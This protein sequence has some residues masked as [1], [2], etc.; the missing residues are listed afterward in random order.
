MPL[1]ISIDEPMKTEKTL[2]YQKMD[3]DA[4]YCYSSHLDKR[5]VSTRQSEHNPMLFL[6]LNRNII[7][8]HELC[9][10]FAGKHMIQDKPKGTSPKTFGTIHVDIEKAPEMA[11]KI[12]EVYTWYLQNK[13]CLIH[14][15]I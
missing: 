4:I 13:G 6:N 8:G 10:V 14:E 12:L 9:I 2:H 15:P 5:I 11:S 3:V 1:S 7:Y